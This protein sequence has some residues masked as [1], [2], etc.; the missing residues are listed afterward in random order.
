MPASNVGNGATVVVQVRDVRPSS[1]IGYRG[2]D[3]KGAEITTDQD[4]APVVQKKI[5]EG[6]TQQ[7]FKAVS[8]GEEPARM[9]KVEIRDLQYTTDMD[10]W[11]GIVRTKAVL[12]ASSRTEGRVYEQLY[13]AE[14][15]EKAAEAPRAKTNAQLINGVLSHA[16][17]RLLGDQRLVRWLAN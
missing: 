1:Q 15:E 3:S 14:R 9:L 4:L 7:G 8:A 2:L 6:L 13:A 12:Q 11:K 10:F 16:L 5:I 17:Q